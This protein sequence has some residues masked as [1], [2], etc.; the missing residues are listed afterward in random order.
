MGGRCVSV[1]DGA[2]ARASVCLTATPSAGAALSGGHRRPLLGGVKP[3]SSPRLIS[4]TS[5]T[6]L[7]C[8]GPAAPGRCCQ[9]RRELALGVLPDWL[10]HWEFILSNSPRFRGLA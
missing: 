10:C 2:A 1:R 7:R 5:R 6:P 4:P 9:Y 8:S 3:R